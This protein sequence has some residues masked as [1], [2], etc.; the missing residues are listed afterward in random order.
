MILSFNTPYKATMFSSIILF[1]GDSRKPKYK[2][3]VSS[4]L[5]KE[6]RIP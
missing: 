6:F 2:N 5:E 1:Y 3:V 4:V